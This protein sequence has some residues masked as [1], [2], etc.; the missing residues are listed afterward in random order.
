VDVLNERLSGILTLFGYA[1]PGRAAG[2]Q[3]P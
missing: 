2:G 1:H 3:R